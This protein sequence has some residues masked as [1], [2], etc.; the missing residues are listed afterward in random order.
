M[1]KENLKARRKRERLEKEAELRK[2]CEAHAIDVFGEKQIKKWSNEHKGLW[3][4]PAR[5][6][7]DDT[8]IIKLGIFKKIDREA[9]NY[10]STKIEDNG[11][12]NFL[13]C[14]MNECWIGGDREIIENDDY[15]LAAS[16]KF[17]KMME[18]YNVDLIKR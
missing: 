5:D 15:F 10:A 6:P 7:D 12:Y 11:L 14:A 2:M 18:G 3:Y 17:N 1:A 8:K 4:L 16:Q 13:E 9:L